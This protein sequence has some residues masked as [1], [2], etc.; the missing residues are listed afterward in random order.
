MFKVNYL[1][2]GKRVAYNKTQL[3]VSKYL[4]ICESAYTMKERGVRK[5][6]IPESESLAILFKLSPIEYVEIFLPNMF[7]QIEHQKPA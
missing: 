3:E 4:G 5:F 6:T 2:K 1:L 7:T